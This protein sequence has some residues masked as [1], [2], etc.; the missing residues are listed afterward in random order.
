MPRLNDR[1]IERIAERFRA[2][3]EPQRIRIVQALEEGEKSVTEI[4]DAVGGSQP[5]VSRHLQTLFEA[6]LV[7]RRRN[8]SWIVYTIADPMVHELCRVVCRSAEQEVRR[9]LAE[10]GAGSR[11]NAEQPAVRRTGR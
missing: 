9:Q 11:R 3:G 7:T 6:G 10:L 5:N 8:G 1:M 4:T 2:L